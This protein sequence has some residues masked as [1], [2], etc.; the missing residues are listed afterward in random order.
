M[1][2]RPFYLNLWYHSVHTPI[3]GK[4]ALV[5]RFRAKTANSVIH[6]N[7]HYAAMVAS[8]DEN[9]GRILQKLEEVGIADRTVV[10]F[11][12]DNGG[13]V[14]PCKLQPGVPV[15]SNAPLR[16]GKG[17][18]YEGGLRVP[19]IMRWPGR[20]QRGAVCDQSVTSCDLLPTLLSMLQVDVPAPPQ[21]DGIDVSS[22]VRE[23]E[24]PLPARPLYFH[25]PHY[26]PTTS[27]VSAVRDGA[28]KLLEFYDGPRVE[29]YNLADDLSETTNLAD[30]QPAVA[31]RLREQLHAWQDSV[32]AQHPT[33]RE[34]AS[35]NPA[36]L[37]FQRA[38]DGVYQFQNA[39]AQGQLGTPDLTFGLFDMQ[40]R[41][42]DQPISGRHGVLNIYRVFSDGQRYGKAAWDWP[43][44]AD[45]LSDGSVRIGCAAQPTRPF[46]LQSTY[47][48]SE[49]DTLDL[50]VRV[51]AEQ[52][53]HDFEVF[54]ASYFDPAFQVCRTHAPAA[55]DCDAA[56]F[57]EARQSL[58]HWLMFPRDPDA[59]RLIQD[60]RWQIP[61]NPVQWEVLPQ[62]GRALVVRQVPDSDLSV[63]LMARRADCFA[64][65]MPFQT[66]NHFS[67]YLSLLGRDIAAGQQAS[68]R[69]RMQ[70]V[71]NVD[72][73]EALSRYDA[74]ETSWSAD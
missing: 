70:I 19:L 20:G 34:L 68:A 36:G 22:L 35:D 45:L 29:L 1:R 60:G 38:G 71:R 69:V 62:F 40:H 66:E 26:Y 23:P 16:S 65:A 9:V 56:G 13:F 3:E 27:P 47:R 4:P 72:L 55:A 54:V 32:E 18:L 53:L 21:F 51:W 10:V 39:V 57:L 73:T 11:F 24:Q 50:E 37:A 2:D 43:G 63:L 8:L 52:D 61:P 14:N 28:W 64:L 15:T 5:E 46:Q 17:S 7:P 67:V 30:T 49:P 12:S 58:G 33:R 74:F 44:Q 41:V 25:Y 42:S 31:Q 48:W 6:T 59:V